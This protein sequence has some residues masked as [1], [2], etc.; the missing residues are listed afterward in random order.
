[1]H[2]HDGLPAYLVLALADT[3]APL[4]R[5]TANDLVDELELCGK[6]IKDAKDS[7]KCVIS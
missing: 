1:M 7:K 5:P 4:Q 2:V 3:A 6:T